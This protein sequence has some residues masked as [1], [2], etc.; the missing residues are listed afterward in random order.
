MGSFLIKKI[1]GKVTSFNC[2][3]PVFLPKIIKPSAEKNPYHT[4]ITNFETFAGYPD[5]IAVILLIFKCNHWI[6]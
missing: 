4:G 2:I 6:H 3:K 5:Y 1:R